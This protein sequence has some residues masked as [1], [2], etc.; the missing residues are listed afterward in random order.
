MRATGKS[1]V[2]RELARRLGEE[3]VDTDELLA[4]RHGR[5]ESAGELLRRLGEPAFRALEAEVLADAL[6]SG[7]VVATGAGA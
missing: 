4:D 3:F 5:G 2:G 6:D 7:G 1:T